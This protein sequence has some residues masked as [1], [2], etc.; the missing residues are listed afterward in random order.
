M[1]P[2]KELETDLAEVTKTLANINPQTVKHR[3]LAKELESVQKECVAGA[4]LITKRLKGME[5]IL[6]SLET[7]KNKKKEA[8]K[9]RNEI[10]NIRSSISQIEKGLPKPSSRLL[11]LII[12]SISVWKPNRSFGLAYKKEYEEYK[13]NFTWLIILASAVILISP[14]RIFESVFQFLLVFFYSTVTVREHILIVNGSRIRNWWMIHQ[15][16]AIGQSL[17]LF[18]WPDG[19]SYDLFR[20]QFFIFSLYLGLVQLAQYW[21]QSRALYAKIAMAGS[22]KAMEITQALPDSTTLALVILALTIAY[23]FQLYN[24]WSLSTIY[25]QGH[26]EWQIPVLALN[27]LLLGG[28]NIRTVYKVVKSKAIT[29]KAGQTKAQEE[30][31]SAKDM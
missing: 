16:L 26:R 6:K 7:N 9:Y 14:G 2:I 20:T 3:E 17:L 13:K 5:S 21:Y 24:A 27:F 18:S 23:V 11:S 29:W 12:G 30:K 10:V 19:T 15:Y 8:D 22:D 28:G 1:D 4:S 31:D 25:L